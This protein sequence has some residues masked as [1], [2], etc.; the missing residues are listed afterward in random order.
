MLVILIIRTGGNVEYVVIG[1]GG[2]GGG[3]HNAGG[4]GGGAGGY[5]F[6][7]LER[8]VDGT[9]PT[10]LL[11]QVVGGSSASIWWRWSQWN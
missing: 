1:Y 11:V 9:G 7:E 4:G 6:Q 5:I 10:S 8:S 2:G 3:G